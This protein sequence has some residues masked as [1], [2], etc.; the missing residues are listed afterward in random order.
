[1][2]NKEKEEALKKFNSLDMG[3]DIEF[4][5]SRKIILQYIDQL[6]KENLA[7]EIQR[8]I[9]LLDLHKESSTIVLKNILNILEVVNDN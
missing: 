4:I 5:K 1:M 2:Q 7:L 9:S 3:D 8:R 6:E